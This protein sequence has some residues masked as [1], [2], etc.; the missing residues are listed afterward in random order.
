VLKPRQNTVRAVTKYEKNRKFCH[1]HATAGFLQRT[2]TYQSPYRE[3][4]VLLRFTR[5]GYT[6]QVAGPAPKRP[7]VECVT[8]ETGTVMLQGNGYVVPS[9]FFPVLMAVVESV[10][11][12]DD[13]CLPTRSLVCSGRKYIATV[14]YSSFACQCLTCQI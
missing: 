12:R 6:A 1:N 2:K 8:P 3:A 5:T 4:E 7:R 14:K 9:S 13:K 10:F 11:S